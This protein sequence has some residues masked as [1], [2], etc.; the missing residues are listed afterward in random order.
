[1]DN[2]IPVLVGIGAGLIVLFTVVYNVVRFKKGKTSCGCDCKSDKTACACCRN[3]QCPSKTAD[4][5]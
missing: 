4:G 1:M 2:L 3:S 5:K